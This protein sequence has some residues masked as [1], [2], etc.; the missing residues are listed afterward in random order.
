[1][2]AALPAAAQE[3]ADALIRDL[4][5]KLA[6]D[7][8]S[9]R[10][11]DVAATD[12]GVQGIQEKID[13]LLSSRVARLERDSS[14][15]FEDY[16]FAPDPNGDLRLRPERKAEYE[17]LRLRLP[18]ALKAMAG[19]NHRA[20]SIVR[21]LSEKDEM[22]KIAKTAWNDS[23][24]RSA[25]FH[26]H[27]ELRELD[28]AE[29]LDAQGFRGLERQAGGALRLGGPYA[30]EARDRMA[31]ILDRLEGLKAYEKSYLKQV[32]A[33]GEAGARATLSSDTATLFLIG[34]VI[35]ETN[36]Q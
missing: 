10:L 17:A 21:R 36:E 6:K 20:D 19:F 13:F 14:G 8:I 30:Q 9:G 27:P 28:D 24:F 22:D 11:A 35:R 7:G 1:M 2:L 23:G 25:F 26:R 31:E 33:V 29:L 3:G 15:C 5:N 18:G 34:R 32:A 12:A 16:L 4:A